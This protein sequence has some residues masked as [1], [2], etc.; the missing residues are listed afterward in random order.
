[1]VVKLI[2]TCA[3]AHGINPDDFAVR[4]K[5]NAPSD[6]AQ[7]HTMCSRP[8]SDASCG[9]PKPEKGLGILYEA[10]VIHTKSG[11]TVVE[12]HKLVAPETGAEAR[13]EGCGIDNKLLDEV[14]K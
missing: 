8:L 13:F 14:L 5:P 11:K 7:P 3:L 1:M 12:L 4:F 6:M 10:Q 9:V 2:L